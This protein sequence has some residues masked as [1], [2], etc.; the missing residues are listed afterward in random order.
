MQER[1]DNLHLDVVQEEAKLR[2]SSGFET[3][4]SHIEGSLTDAHLKMLMVN[5]AKRVLGDVRPE[6]QQVI[7]E[8]VDAHPAYSK[9]DPQE[10][11]SE[12]LD[13]AA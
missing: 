11:A 8:Y 7:E 5:E 1:A 3:L 9:I 13:I 6:Q 4:I 10:L 2:L 12:I